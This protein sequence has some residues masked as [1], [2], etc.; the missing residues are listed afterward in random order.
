MFAYLRRM[1]RA[2]LSCALLAAVAAAPVLAHDDATLDATESP[3]GGQL[4]MAGNHHYELVVVKSGAAGEHP[5]QVYVS[6]HAGTPQDVAGARAQAVMQSGKLRAWVTL[7]P[8]GPNSFKGW[9]K[10]P[11]APDLTVVLTV[12]FADGS[13]EQARFTPLARGSRAQ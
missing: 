2:T 1:R 7:Q 11:P 9:A 12:T 10:Y 5:V 13:M 8:D 3:H 6:N 4:R